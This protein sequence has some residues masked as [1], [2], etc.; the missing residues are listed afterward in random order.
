MTSSD[1]QVDEDLAATL[2]D[3]QWEVLSLVASGLSNAQVGAKL[4][5]GTEAVKSHLRKIMIT[6][7]LRNRAE[8]AAYAVRQLGGVP[9]RADPS[10][11]VVAEV[12]LTDRQQQIAGQLAAGATNAEIARDLG[13]GVQTVKSHVR[14]IL[15][16]LGATNRAQ[17]AA[18]VTDMEESPGRCERSGAMA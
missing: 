2:T 18:Q 15:R 8:V 14:C 17:V 1:G 9:V 11:P 3:R 10:R 4:F 12:R 6:L 13:I 16:K 7:E 5:I